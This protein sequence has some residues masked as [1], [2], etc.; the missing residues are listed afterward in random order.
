MGRRKFK[1]TKGKV[2]IAVIYALVII[3]FEHP[4]T[5]YFIVPGAL[6][7]GAY[8]Y[9]LTFKKYNRNI[10]KVTDHLFVALIYK[11]KF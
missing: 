8:F 2:I 1:Y 4:N 3:I 9:L 11:Y 10:L 6:L 5:L 7:V